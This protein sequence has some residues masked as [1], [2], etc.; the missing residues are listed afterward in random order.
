VT[1]PGPPALG[2]GVVIL[3]GGTVPAPW[4]GVPA[5][6]VDEEVVAAPGPAVALLHEAWARRRAVV[7]VAGVDPASFRQPHSYP[8]QPWTLDAAFEAWHDRLAFLVW[9]NNYDARGAGG[10]VWWWGRKAAR[11][12]AVE[13]GPADVVLADGRPAWIDGGP[14]GPLAITELIVHSETVDLGRLTVMAKSGGAAGDPAAELAPDQLAAVTHA[15]GPARVIA[16]AGSGKT[17]VLTERLRHLVVDRAYERETV[18]AVAYNVKA[19]EEMA[20]RT[21]TFAPRIQSLNALGFSLL[22]QAHGRD[23]GP[24]VLDEVQVRDVVEQVMPRRQRRANVDP[25]A[26]YLEGLSAIRLGLRDPAEVEDSLDDADGLAAGFEP[27]RARLAEAGAVDFDDQ[28]Y[29]AIELLLR[30]GTF[31]RQ[32]QRGCRH[33]LVDEFQDLTPAH[34]L[35][36]RLLASPGLDVFG[37]GDDD[38]VIYG[39]AGADPGFLIGFDSLFP[40]AASHPLEVNY[41]CPVPVVEGARTLLSYNRRRVAKTIVASPHVEDSPA[42]LEVRL[43]GPSDGAR[44]VV[45]VARGWLTGPATASDIAVLARVNSLLLAPHVALVEAGVP[46][47]SIVGTEVLRRTGVRAALAYLRIGAEP[48]AIRGADVVEVMRRPSRALPPWFADRI[49]RRPQWTLAGLGSLVATV[50]DKDQAKVAGLVD[51]LTGVAAVLAGGDTVA[52]LDY[53]RD[54]IGL[55]R[56]MSLLDGGRQGSS[57]LDDL[58]GLAQVAALHPDPYAF[59][60]W[61]RDLLGRP[62]DAAGVTLSTVHRVKGREWPFVVVFGVTDGIVPHRLAEDLEEERR[63]FHVAITRCRSRVVVLGDRGRRSPFLAELSGRAPHGPVRPALPSPLS[64]PARTAHPGTAADRRRREASPAGDLPPLPT[65]AEP[66]EAALRAWR[67]QRAKQDQVAAFIVL[68]NRVMR[69]V[70]ILDPHTLDDLAGVGGVGPSKLDRYGDE[71]LALLG[72]LR[73]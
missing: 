54:V 18:L 56:A 57:N 16:P 36:L 55:G 24:R 41:R 69:A 32:A 45:D 1:A 52:A 48:D 70:A 11:L 25:Y 67:S 35:L 21:S 63:V 22:R 43:H 29:G 47:D 8:V 73:P 14:R 4:A 2:R 5:V 50:P 7:V 6:V 9:A 31:R 72:S 44:Q 17:R 53:T 60:P 68:T 65:D 3:A 23:G 30:D 39:H 66:R 28:I 62:R 12:G 38:Q 20:A 42:A 46:V 71:L 61:L 19:R 33:V 64:P 51:D 37:V 27:F 26:V 10:P 13:A 58:D 15:S 49:G 34:V 40:G 59:E